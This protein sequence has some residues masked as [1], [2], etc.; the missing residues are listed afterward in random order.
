[1]LCYATANQSSRKF[2]VKNCCAI[3]KEVN[4]Y[5]PWDTTQHASLTYLVDW[6]WI[7]GLTGS[8][9]G[10]LSF[11]SLSITSSLS[12]SNSLSK[13]NKPDNYQI[14]FKKYRNPPNKCTSI[15]GAT[16][17]P[18]VYQW[19]YLSIH[20]EANISA[21]M[22]QGQLFWEIW[23]PYLREFL[24]IAQNRWSYCSFEPERCQCLSIHPNKPWK[25]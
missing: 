9:W 17:D 11:F 3:P 10:C 1:M 4:K 22:D 20:Q 6:G 14:V 2:L 18:T 8:V 7:S 12:F 23:M 24:C 25:Q 13:V 5:A 15:V 21:L 16:K 19:Q